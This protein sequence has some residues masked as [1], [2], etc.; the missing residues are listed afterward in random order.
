M[1]RDPP[2][3]GSGW[4]AHCSIHHCGTLRPSAPAGQSLEMTIPAPASL[5]WSQE[6]RS[7]CPSRHYSHSRMWHPGI[8]KFLSCRTDPFVHAWL[9]IHTFMQPLPSASSKLLGVEEGKPSTPPTSETG[10]YKL[11]CQAVNFIIH[12]HYLIPHRCVHNS[13]GFSPG[14]PDP[15]NSPDITF[16]PFS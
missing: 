3:P 15:A 1:I 9:T 12:S 10:A 5:P 11:P 16:V 6:N 13:Q 4:P 8:P 2:L 14:P 7:V